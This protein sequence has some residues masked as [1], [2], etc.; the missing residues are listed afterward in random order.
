MI[1]PNF[2]IIGAPK[3]G[4]S[5]LYA[6]LKQHREIY[7][8]PVKEPHF[9]MLDDKKVDFQGP[10]DQERF[11]AAVHRIEDYYRLFEDVTDEIAIG[12]ASTT[13]LGSVQA[14]ERIKRSIPDVKLIV[15]L[16]NPVD[17]AFAS[18]LHLVRDGDESLNDFSKALQ[19][20]QDRTQKNWGLIWR[21]QQR[22]F[23]YKQLNQYFKLFDKE[24][25]KVY[26]YEEFREEP[27]T[28][29]KDIFIFLGVS[30]S[31]KP[32]ISSRHNVSGMPKSFLINKL[33]AKKNPLK[34]SV[35]LLMPPTIRHKFYDQIRLWNF[36]DFKKPKMPV[37]IREQLTHTYREDILNLQDL[38]QKDL[39]EWLDL[40]SS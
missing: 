7:M 24:Q 10:G 12:E 18:F 28:I 8:S 35:K 21:Y 2:L 32:D 34:D 36:N 13:Y 5:A 19:A 6:Y 3:A 40:T 31:F 23:Y 20:E 17:A 26:I 33:L 9:F 22:G 16:R 25:I 27:H 4:T 29:L 1:L 30:P 38:I 14:S 39:S 15:I 11:K 37:S